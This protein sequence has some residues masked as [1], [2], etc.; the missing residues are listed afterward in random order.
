MARIDTKIRRGNAIVR[1][2]NAPYP[3]E[4]IGV[5]TPKAAQAL[6]DRAAVEQPP[7]SIIYS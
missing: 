7:R 3:H 5:A 1:S 4:Y 2:S 6:L